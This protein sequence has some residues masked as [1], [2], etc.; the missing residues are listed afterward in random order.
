MSARR[1]ARRAAWG[2]AAVLVLVG[3]DPPIMTGLDV[4]VTSPAT[5]DVM[6][7]F[8]FGGPQECTLVREAYSDPYAS[9]SEVVDRYSQRLQA[10]PYRFEAVPLVLDA[11]SVPADETGTLM[12]RPANASGT[13]QRISVGCTFRDGFVDREDRILYRPSPSFE[14]VSPEPSASIGRSPVEVEITFEADS[15]AVCRL[16]R[17]AEVDGGPAESFEANVSPADGVSVVEAVPL[18]AESRDGG[19]PVPTENLISVSC[20]YAVDGVAW[21]Q[22]VET[23]VWFAPSD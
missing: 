21:T 7:L 18:I 2:F 4:V 15:P 6:P 17:S 9:P 8:A 23:S 5:V 16:L 12:G 10:F 3:C 11:S 22:V 13:Q 14:V 19:G 1:L 20:P